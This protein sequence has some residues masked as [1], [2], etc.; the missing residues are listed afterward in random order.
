MLLKYLFPVA[1]TN[2]LVLT[3]VYRKYCANIGKCDLILKI[4]S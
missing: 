1:E 3:N 4:L 2:Y